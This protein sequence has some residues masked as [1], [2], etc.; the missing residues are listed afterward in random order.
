MPEATIQENANSRSSKNNVGFTSQQRGQLC[1]HRKSET[2]RVQCSANRN[3]Q[4]RGFS[5]VRPHHFANCWG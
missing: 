4:P 1:I 2:L 5:N 3:F